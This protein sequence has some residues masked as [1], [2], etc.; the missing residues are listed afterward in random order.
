MACGGAP[1]FGW[2]CEICKRAEALRAVHSASPKP[3]S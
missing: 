2:I 1:Y 3:R